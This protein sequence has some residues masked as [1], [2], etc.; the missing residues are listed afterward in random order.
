MKRKIKEQRKKN[1]THD[2]A[3]TTDVM[4]SFWMA[5]NEYFGKASL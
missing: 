1:R 2:V 5:S 3:M 4:G